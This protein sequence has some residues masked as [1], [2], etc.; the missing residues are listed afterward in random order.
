MIIKTMT[1]PEHSA[2]S[3]K[4]GS[5]DR[6]GGRAEGH[7]ARRLIEPELA[8]KPDPRNVTKVSTGSSRSGPFQQARR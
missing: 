3:I 6:R 4:S 5:L 2:F 8:D 7:I 1:H